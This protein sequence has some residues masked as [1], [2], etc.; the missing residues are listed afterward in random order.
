MTSSGVGR[1]TRSAPGSRRTTL[2]ARAD[3]VEPLG[4]G[5][6]RA[7][8]DDRAHARSRRRCG[9][10]C[11]SGHITL[12]RAGRDASRRVLRGLDRHVLAYRAVESALRA[13]GWHARSGC[14]RTPED[15]CAVHGYALAA[16]SS[17]A[18]RPQGTSRR[19]PRSPTRLRRSA[20]AT[21]TASCSRSRFTP[22]ATCSILGGRVREGLALLDEAMVT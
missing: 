16:A 4:P 1:P 14:S 6:S 11:S 8:R 15:D 12:P 22:R 20:S 18:T 3:E 19:R 2:L 21:A 5:G 13:A 9:R 10:R 17:S 7:A